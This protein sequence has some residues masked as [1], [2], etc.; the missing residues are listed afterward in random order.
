MTFHDK[1]APSHLQRELPK[2]ASVNSSQTFHGLKALPR[3]LQIQIWEEYFH[4]V[5][6]PVHELLRGSISSLWIY[7]Q[8]QG[9]F[10]H[11]CSC[12]LCETMIPKPHH[13][14]IRLSHKIVLWVDVS[15]V[16]NLEPILGMMRFCTTT[17]MVVL[18]Y[19]RM[20]AGDDGDTR[21]SFTFAPYVATV[22][23]NCK[24][25]KEKLMDALEELLQLEASA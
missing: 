16:E 21:T 3:E 13:V 22:E 18:R 7:T 12:K 14:A 15:E 24:A 11:T 23:R 17:Q 19:W 20:R 8:T 25:L 10:C 1:N 4:K 5:Y 6:S 2:A 9:E